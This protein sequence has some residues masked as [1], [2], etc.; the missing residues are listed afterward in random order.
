M[1]EQKPVHIFLKFLITLTRPF[2]KIFFQCPGIL[3]MNEIKVGKL[4]Q[5]KS[6]QKKKKK[7]KKK[8]IYQI[9]L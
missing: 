9:N 5:R 2:L 6:R 1:Y 3:K 4:L 7:K 8:E